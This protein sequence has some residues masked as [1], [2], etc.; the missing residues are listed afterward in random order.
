MVLLCVFHLLW[1]V[2]YATGALPAAVGAARGLLGAAAHAAIV[3]RFAGAYSIEGTGLKY[4]CAHAT[5]LRVANY[6]LFATFGLAAINEAVLTVL[7]LRG[8]P[9]ETRKRR[10]MNPLLYLEIVL[11]GLLLAFTIYATVTVY[12][13]AVADSC[14][15]NNPCQYNP[16]LF[17]LAC[18]DQQGTGTIRSLPQTCQKLLEAGPNFM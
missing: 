16:D 14:W 10:F 18:R 9:F 5:E 8:G 4:E 17:P 6:S 2:P 7:G 13:P 11:W 3:L 1:F 12:S 15:S